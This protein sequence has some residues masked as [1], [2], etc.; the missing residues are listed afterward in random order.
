M[1]LNIVS[2]DLEM[3]THEGINP[4]I[5]IGCSI[6]HLETRTILDKKSFLVHIGEPITP[7]ITSLTGIT[8][9]MIKD[10][11]V[12]IDAY[13]NMVSW[14]EPYATQKMPIVWGNGDIRTLKSQLIQQSDLNRDIS[15]KEWPFGYSEMNVKNLVQADLVANGKSM[16]GGLAKSMTRYGLKFEG[17]KH[18]ADDDSLNTLKMYFCMLDLLKQKK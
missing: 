10:A 3:N 2:L 8:D 7:F 9:E 18:R 1:R 6:G 17:T 14:L 4:I 11:P 5:E 13:N 12:L 16:Q 15:I